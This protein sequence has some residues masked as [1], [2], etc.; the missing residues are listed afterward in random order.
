[1]FIGTGM[2][3]FSFNFVTVYDFFSIFARVKPKYKYEQDY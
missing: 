1:M 2:K 3:C